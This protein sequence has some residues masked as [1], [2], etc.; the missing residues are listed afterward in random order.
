MSRLQGTIEQ[1]Y[2]HTLRD[3]ND[4]DV[5]R[6]RQIKMTQSSRIHLPL[7]LF[8]EAGISSLAFLRKPGLLHRASTS[9]S[10]QGEILGRGWGKQGRAGRAYDEA[11]RVAIPYPFVVDHDDGVGS[12]YCLPPPDR[13]FASV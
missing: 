9:K 4:H 6:Y 2:S 8:L 10:L 1:L 13:R 7:F 12:D 5:S 3:N 11:G